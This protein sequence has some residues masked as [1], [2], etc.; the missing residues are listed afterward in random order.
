M[1]TALCYKRATLHKSNKN[2]WIKWN[3]RKWENEEFDLF[4]THPYYHLI[5]FQLSLYIRRTAGLLAA[6]PWNSLA[7]FVQ[8]HL[9][10]DHQEWDKVWSKRITWLSLTFTDETCSSPPPS[11]VISSPIV[12]HTAIFLYVCSSPILWVCI[13][14][15]SKQSARFRT[16]V[17]TDVSLRGIM[18]G[19]IYDDDA[20]HCGVW[21]GPSCRKYRDCTTRR[22]VD[23]WLLITI[24][25]GEMRRKQMDVSDGLYGV[26]QTK[27]KCSQV[28][29]RDHFTAKA[30]SK[31]WRKRKHCENFCLCLPIFYCDLKIHK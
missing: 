18:D 5:R 6:A 10:L 30:C 8:S 31:S 17:R 9:P 19:C 25:I 4:P 26:W 22:V 14:L 11:G 21:S 15:C 27:L 13:Y 3:Y 29:A 28:V 24:L 20:K 7:R 2:Y 1:C 16:Y 23:G 12:G